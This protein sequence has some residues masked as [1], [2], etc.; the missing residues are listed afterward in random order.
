[1]LVLLRLLGWAGRRWPRP[2]LPNRVRVLVAYLVGVP[3]VL[4][5]YLEHLVGVHA[6]VL[7]GNPRRSHRHRAARGDVLAQ[8]LGVRHPPVLAQSRIRVAPGRGVSLLQV[9]RYERQPSVDHGEHGL[10]HSTRR[11][12]G[13]GELRRRQDPRGRVEAN[14]AGAL[15]PRGAADKPRVTVAEDDDGTLGTIAQRHQRQ[16]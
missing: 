13:R 4:V 2:D 6:V 8:K 16:R 3:R 15:T 7:V 9:W 14:R 11:V 10:T 1:M 5:D 12:T